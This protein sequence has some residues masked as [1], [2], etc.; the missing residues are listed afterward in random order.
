MHCEFIKHDETTI[1]KQDCR[2][3]LS[4]LKACFFGYTKAQKAQKKLKLEV[5]CACS[6]T[7][8]NNCHVWLYLFCVGVFG[9]RGKLM[10]P[11]V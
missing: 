9:F 6:P 8:V 5:N 10:H 3:H 2:L 1:I 7:G 11:T 4:Q